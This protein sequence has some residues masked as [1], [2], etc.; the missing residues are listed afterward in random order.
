MLQV[1]INDCNAKKMELPTTREHER[2]FISEISEITILAAQNDKKVPP[3][4]R[5]SRAGAAAL[6]GLEVSKGVMR[7]PTQVIN[8]LRSPCE[9]TMK[10]EVI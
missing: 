1:E 4:H 10:Q 7:H 6:G 5:G 2:D 9:T 3:A 8:T